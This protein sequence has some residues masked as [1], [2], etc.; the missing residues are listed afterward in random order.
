MNYKYILKNALKFKWKFL[1]L[2]FCIITTSFIGITYPYIFGRL[3][4]EVFYKKN[5]SMFINIVIIYGAIYLVEQ[6]LHL[7]LNITWAQLMTRFLFVIRKDLF[8]KTLSLTPKFLSNIHTGDVIKRIN[9][10]VEEFMNFIHWN[11]FY[12]IA[13]ILRLILAIGALFF[14]NY[15]IAILVIAL[16]PINVFLSK[17]FGKKVKRFYRKKAD[18]EGIVSS[19]LFEIIKGMREICLLGA[20]NE[21]IKKFTHKTIEIMRIK[22]NSDTDIIIFD[23]ATSALDY[24]SE[25][26]IHKTIEELCAE[27]TII[28]IAHRLSSILLADKVIVMDNGEVVGQGNNNELLGNNEVY[29]T[30]FKEQYNAALISY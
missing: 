19:W 27:K 8:N 10:D 7:V 1:I 23:E 11:I 17:Y 26:M 22:I 30:L 2:F 16:I 5:M 24:E 29:D 28:I 20:E 21:I 9:K 6:L 25:K 13:N 3:V 15:K 18:K 14:L 12:T 4:D